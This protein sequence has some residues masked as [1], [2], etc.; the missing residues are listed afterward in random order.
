MVAEMAALVEAL[1]TRVTYFVVRIPYTVSSHCA[2]I[3][4]W[5]SGVCW[6]EYIAPADN[7]YT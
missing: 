5:S 4:A 1:G 3:L 6:V 7:S 2:D